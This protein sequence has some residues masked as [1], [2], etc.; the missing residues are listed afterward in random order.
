MVI[1][2]EVRVGRD[3]RGD[4]SGLDIE[5]RHE[6]VDH[7]GVGEL[8]VFGCAAHLD[9]KEDR[10]ETIV[11]HLVQSRKSFASCIGIFSLTEN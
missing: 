10:W 7:S 3:W 5:S 1:G 6:G 11:T 2:R 9:T 8:D 4:E